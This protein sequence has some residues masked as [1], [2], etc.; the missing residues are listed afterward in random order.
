M[1]AATNEEY[2][3]DIDSVEAEI[4]DSTYVLQ[5]RDKSI[6]N[7]PQ[8]PSVMPTGSHFPTT[9]YGDNDTVPSRD[10]IIT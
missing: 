4:S 8:N 9:L 7:N 6:S 3:L 5:C 1:L 2:F 10:G